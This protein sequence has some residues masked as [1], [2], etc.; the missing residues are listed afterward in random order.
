M[1]WQPKDLMDTKREFVELALQ[2]GANRRELCRRFG[3]GAKAAYALLARYAQEGDGAEGG[4]V[5]RPERLHLGLDEGLDLLEEEHLAGLRERIFGEI[6][7]RTLETDLSVPS[8]RGAWWYYGRTI[9]GKQYG[10]QCRAPLAAPDDWTPPE[11]TPGE[12]VPGEQV[13]LDANVEAEG[14]EFFSLGS[15]DVSDDGR[16]MLF[17]VDVAGDERYTIRV[18][19]LATGVELGLE[20]DTV[21]EGLAA[22]ERVPGRLEPVASGRDFS[23]F[24]D[25]AHTTDALEAAL[26]T[27]AALAHRRILTVFGCGGDRDATK[28]ESMG[29]AACRGSDL[30]FA[31]SDNPRGEDPMEILRQIERGMRPASENYKIIPDRRQAIFEAVRAA[32][33]GDIVLIAGKGHETVQI[34]KDKTLP[35]DDREV[36]REAL[37]G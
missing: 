10:V 11:L 36:A 7:D 16:L 26:S 3:I 24:V 13:L 22:L 19:D 1:P 12:P 9:E 2:E 14:T 33:S 32:Q 4:G 29:S 37:A 27:L 8:R 21:L 17:G 25:Y 28:R 34:L 15:F 30:V 18:R 5:L 23:V 20:A 35:F 6:K 31:T